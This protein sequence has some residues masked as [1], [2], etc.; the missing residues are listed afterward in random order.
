MKLEYHTHRDEERIKK[1]GVE[2][3]MERENAHT[4]AQIG[5]RICKIHKY[6]PNFQEASTK[7]ES[8][9]QAMR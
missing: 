1:A 5:L 4:K 9:T 8:K 7:L 2:K 6:E 3:M